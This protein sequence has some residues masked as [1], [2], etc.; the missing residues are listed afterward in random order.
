ML[1]SI[2]S[3]FVLPLF[4]GCVNRCAFLDKF[5]VGI[6][7]AAE[8]YSVDVA[9]ARL[10]TLFMMVAVYMN[11]VERKIY[12]FVFR[13]G[14]KQILP[15]VDQLHGYLQIGFMV[16]IRLCDRDRMSLCS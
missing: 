16:F 9:I 13:F 5:A 11:G 6:I 3:L 14:T 12:G 10:P 8:V 15:I 4:N 7:T 2:G 1:L